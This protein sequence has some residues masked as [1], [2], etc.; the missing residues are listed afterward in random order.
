MRL[1]ALTRQIQDVNATFA[2]PEASRGLYASAGG[3]ARLVRCVGLPVAS[4]IALTGRILT[5]DDAKGLGL[6]NVV[7]GQPGAKSVVEAAVEMAGRIAALSPD[8]VIITRAGLRMAL[9]EGSVE[10]ATQRTEERYGI[11][12]RQAENFGIGLEA[13][14]KRE[15]PKWVPSKL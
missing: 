12:M 2:L 11:A 6:V 14:A 15:K 10:T 9:E 8:A 7:A 4:E 13:F 3:L 1:K 5:A